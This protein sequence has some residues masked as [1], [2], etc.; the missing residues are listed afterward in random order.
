MNTNPQ[1][2]TVSCIQALDVA[3]RDASRVYREPN[4]F[5][6]TIVLAD[7]GWHIDYSLT[8]P[9]LCGG[10]PHYVI[11]AGSGAILRKRYDQ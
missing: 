10:G 4:K 3:H 2:P 7:H 8:D 1:V 6:I 9:D 11:D 5:Q